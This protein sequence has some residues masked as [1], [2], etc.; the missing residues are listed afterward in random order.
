MSGIG[1]R[2]EVRW[3]LAGRA[4]FAWPRSSWFTVTRAGR[5]IFGRCLL[6]PVTDL[7]CLDYR[8]L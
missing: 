6:N 7:S 1:D 8:A 2:T 4:G 3:M 5:R